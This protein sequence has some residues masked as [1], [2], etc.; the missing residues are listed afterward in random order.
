[1][2]KISA[3]F[4][5]DLKRTRKTLANVLKTFQPNSAGD[6]TTAFV[7][8]CSHELKYSSG[9][10]DGGWQ[11]PSAVENVMDC[12]IEHVGDCG[13]ILLK[14]KT[15]LRFDWSAYEAFYTGTRS[16][17]GKGREHCRNVDML[18][19]AISIFKKNL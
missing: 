11:G 17:P 18:T 13:M 14:N 16:D 19:R 1:M 10:C 7:L 5:S 2:G 12:S 3:F 9:D 8:P 4:V 6:I 15:V